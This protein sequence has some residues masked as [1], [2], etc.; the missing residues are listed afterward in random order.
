MIIIFVSNILFAFE[1]FNPIKTAASLAIGEAAEAYGEAL[2]WPADGET[3]KR[4]GIDLI[5]PALGA[6]SFDVLD[7]ALDSG[8]YDDDI[9]VDEVPTSP[10]SVAGDAVVFITARFCNS[11]RRMDPHFRRMQQSFNGV[12]FLRSIQQQIGPS[13]RRPASPARRPASSTK[14]LQE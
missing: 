13:P 4:F 10:D 3:R 6:V 1:F 9:E 2:G 12:R 14:I 8:D 11:C 5:A 7:E